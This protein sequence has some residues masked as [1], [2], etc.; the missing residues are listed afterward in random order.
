[1]L[2]ERWASS[3]VHPCRRTQMQ[4]NCFA[5]RDGGLPRLGD[6]ASRF[7][8]GDQG[9]GKLLRSPISRTL[10]LAGAGLV[11]I[12]PFFW[13]GTPSGHDF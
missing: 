10:A 5:R 12:A 13:W 1:L 3:P 9:P 4:E 8:S 7:S 6:V 2:V 11:A